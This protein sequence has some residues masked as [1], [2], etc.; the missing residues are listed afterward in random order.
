MRHHPNVDI[1]SD[2]RVQD[3]IA[4]IV[5]HPDLAEELVTSMRA[6]LAESPIRGDPDVL[7]AERFFAARDAATLDMDSHPTG[8]LLKALIKE[9]WE[10]TNTKV[11]RCLEF[12]YSHMVNKFKGD[13]AEFLAVRL[14]TELAQEWKRDGQLPPGAHF[15]WGSDLRERRRADLDTGSGKSWHKGADGL[16]IVE[17]MR[18]EGSTLTVFGVVEVKSYG[19]SYRRAE[20]QIHYHLTR[21][22]YGLKIGEQEWSPARLYFGKWNPR[23]QAW[24]QTPVTA[25]TPPEVAQLLVVPSRRER[26]SMLAWRK[27]SRDTFLATLPH[28]SDF[29]AAAAY[30]MTVWFIEQLGCRVFRSVPSPWPEMTPE[31]AGVNAVKQALY[32]IL[33]RKLPERA[34][35]IATRLYNVYGFGY[36]AAKGHKGVLWSVEGKVVSDDER[37]EPNPTSEVPTGMRLEDIV[38][39]AWS[40]Y[41]TCHMDEATAH[42]DAAMS[43]DPDEQ[44]MHRLRWLRG[45]IHYFR[46]EFEQA[47]REL[48]PPR[49]QPQDQWWAKDKLTRARVFARLDRLNEAVSEI[50]DV[51]AAQLPARFLPISVSVCEAMVSLKQGRTNEARRSLDVA[52]HALQI[53]QAEIE[54]RKA[55]GLGIHRPYAPDTSEISALVIDMLPV[56][57]SLGDQARAI[58]LLIHVHDV[59][60][61]YLLLMP[62]DPILEPLRQNPEL[63]PRFLA[64]LQEKCRK[65]GLILA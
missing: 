29:L 48:P 37:Q 31:E 9:D 43:M 27:L 56:Y 40:F 19:L 28:T 8:D 39:R 2:P 26:P 23:R 4:R 54:T 30:E 60:S 65:A 52:F 55:Q 61:P 64:W 10:Q 49:P 50:Q 11:V 25:T 51:T 5:G 32:Y 33:L 7:V 20:P 17:E 34:E 53:E 42:I 63:G 18:P 21:L 44:I 15:I 36:N 59:F 24:S 58:E 38:D 45:M 57:V 35:R 41:R 62:R 47:A 12:I 6:G 14:C 46:A 3:T 1:G 22:R 16:F 13:L